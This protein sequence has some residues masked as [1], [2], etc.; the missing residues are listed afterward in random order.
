[1][2]CCEVFLPI[3]KLSGKS[4]VALSSSSTFFSETARAVCGFPPHWC[5][6]TNITALFLS[7]L[8]PS[9]FW[10]YYFPGEAFLSG[11]PFF[12]F[13]DALAF[14]TTFMKNAFAGMNPASKQTSSLLYCFL[15]FYHFL[16]QSQK[17][18]I[19]HI[20]SQIR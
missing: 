19:F 7:P 15:I 4:F 11:S 3:F 10:R 18:T 9:Q 20:Y 13:R 16:H 12:L 17:F 6:N 8:P 5:L 2:S 14:S 1:M